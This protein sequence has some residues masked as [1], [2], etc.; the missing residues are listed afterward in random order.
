MANIPQRALT[1]GE[2]DPALHSRTDLIKYHTGAKALRNVIVRKSG[3]A[4]SRGG[5]IM[6]IP[7]LTDKFARF[8]PYIISR[9]DSFILE[10]TNL[11]VRV[12]Q[13]GVTVVATL[14]VP[15][16]EKDLRLLKFTQTGTFLKIAHADYPLLHLFRDS[17]NVWQTLTPSFDRP[18]GRLSGVTASAGGTGGAAIYY[19]G[20]T[21]INQDGRES[22]D[23]NATTNANPTLSP[24]NYVQIG[25]NSDAA[26]ITY[27]I[28]KREYGVWS[29]LGV[30]VS[31][32]AGY[33]A[34]MFRDI[35]QSTDASVTRPVGQNPFNSPGNYPAFV[36][37]GQ[38][39]DWFGSTK[40]DPE[41]VWSTETGY[42]SSITG[43]GPGAT[44]IDSDS[45]IFKMDG[46]RLNRVNDMIDVGGLV[47][48]TDEGEVYL[49]G[50]GDGVLTPRL[51]NP[52]FQTHNGTERNIFPLLVNNNALYLQ[53]GGK[54]IRELGF[55]YE[56][57][58]YRGDDLTTFA[59]HLFEHNII[60]DWAFQKS[61][62]SLVW[63]IRN[64]GT[65]ISLTYVKEQQIIA[66]TRHDFLDGFAESIICIP[67]GSHD[68]VYVTV[69]RTVSGVER[70]YI[71]K[72]SDRFVKDR[73]E[74]RLLDSSLTYDGRNFD[75]SKEITV[76]TG[77]SW[78]AG[79]TLTLIASSSVFTLSDIGRRFFFYNG[80]QIYRFTVTS[81]ISGT[82]V[83]GNSYDSTP[84]WAQG[85]SLKR[86]AR[87][88]NSVSGL[89]HLEGKTVSVYGDGY[90][91][92]S[93]LN[94]SY[95]VKTVVGGAI[96][97][98]D[99][100]A[101][102]HV[103]LPYISDIQ[104]LPI[105]T[106]EGESIAAEPK[107]INEVLIRFINSVGGF[108]G[109]KV[110]TDNSIDGL[111]EIKPRTIE[112]LESPNKVLNE[113]VKHKIPASWENNGSVLIRQVD[114]SP[115]EVGFIAP[116]GSISKGR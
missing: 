29:L 35:G 93:P 52:K 37:N 57:D 1:G 22:V 82:V 58:G 74:L 97:L 98:P 55:S 99:H 39:R 76:T 101:L 68:T 80:D 60:I 26:G 94:P 38:Q 102:V 15:Y 16:L 2:L 88:V 28:Y 64:D 27:N 65:L 69:K 12:I 21:S 87:A 83:S 34:D 33:N 43:R 73:Q 24:T 56:V 8:I 3:G 18:P 67:E 9:N 100:Y 14:D 31:T 112:G 91:V 23:Y 7:T 66:W 77:T 72:M 13:N 110:P 81:Y 78:E 105:D 53:S 10:F 113:V 4:A 44:V 96:S 85:V 95:P 11:K 50:A 89:S 54:V 103:G 17:S 92:A 79:Q 107:L 45:I 104:T 49:A 114:P 47:M 70:R 32:A 36:A 116:S 40:N 109:T 115:L 19:Y 84:L 108:V 111:V 71:E 5:T 75:D 25:W 48:F 63:A 20:V 106:P 42:Y 59:G 86:W 90:V 51:V 41:K 62:N 46:T 61:P 6:C 30:A